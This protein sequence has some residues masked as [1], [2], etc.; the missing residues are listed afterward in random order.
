MLKIVAL[1]SDMIKTEL[2]IW[3]PDKR[4]SHQFLFRFEW[5]SIKREAKLR[6]KCFSFLF[7][8]EA[9]FHARS[10]LALPF[11]AELNLTIN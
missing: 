6:I 4:A 5:R 2:R 10:S 8:R 7:L 3:S 11:L 1:E 9:S